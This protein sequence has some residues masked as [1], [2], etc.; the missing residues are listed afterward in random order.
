MRRRYTDRHSRIQFDDFISDP[1]DVDGGLD[2]GDAHSGF[3][4][5][6]YNSDLA[7]MAEEEHDEA[8]VVYID[9]DTLL[10]VGDNFRQTHKSLKNMMGR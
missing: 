4:Y 2:Q 7:E 9:D 3:A 8:T 5:L 6:V 10:T 1:F